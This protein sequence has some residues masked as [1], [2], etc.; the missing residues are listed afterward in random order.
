MVVNFRSRRSQTTHIPTLSGW[1]A[2]RN[3]VPPHRGGWSWLILKRVDLP[4]RGNIPADTI[5]AQAGRFSWL[6][7]S[8]ALK[9]PLR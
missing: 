6:I 5:A 3:N 9:S 2:T 7:R 1:G 8:P 4:L